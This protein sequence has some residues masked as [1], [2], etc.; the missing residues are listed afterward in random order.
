MLRALFVG[1]PALMFVLGIPLA[2]KLVPPNRF[3]GFRTSA[4]FS[5]PEAWYQVNFATG[6]ALVAAGVVA[7]VLAL[8]LSSGMSGLKQENQYLVSILL[9][10][11]LTL[12]F[13]IPVVIY[14][15]RF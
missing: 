8:L 7:G 3:Y 1:L 10:V 2:L 14:S 5:S 13:T 12:A 11:I 4:T 9:T 15:N 6:L